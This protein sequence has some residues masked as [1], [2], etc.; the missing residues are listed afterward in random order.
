MMMTSLNP[1][2]RRLAP[3]GSARV[4]LTTVLILLV[5]S[6]SVAAW[7]YFTSGSTIL[8]P[9]W[10]TFFPSCGIAQQSPASLRTLSSSSVTEWDIGLSF[11]SAGVGKPC[12]GD[13]VVSDRISS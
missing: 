3:F 8:A 11:R 1:P 12:D 7:D 13:G 5:G 6:Q 9:T 4:C 10:Q 2:T